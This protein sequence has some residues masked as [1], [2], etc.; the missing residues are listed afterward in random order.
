VTATLTPA[1]RNLLAKKERLIAAVTIVLA[2]GRSR[3]LRYV[4]ALE[5]TRST[6]AGAHTNAVRGE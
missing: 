3:P 2:A 1:G 5:L 6:P 4:S